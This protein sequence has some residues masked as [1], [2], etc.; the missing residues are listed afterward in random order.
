MNKHVNHVWQY[1]QSTVL[2]AH[3]LNGERLV[4]VLAASDGESPAVAMV[5]PRQLDRHVLRGH[6]ERGRRDVTRPMSCSAL[7]LQLGQKV[8]K[9]HEELSKYNRYI[10]VLFPNMSTLWGTVSTQSPCFALCSFGKSGHQ[11]SCIL[12]AVKAQ[13]PVAHVK[14]ALQNIMTEWTA[15]SVYSL[16]FPLN[17]QHSFTGQGQISRQS[18]SERRAMP[19]QSTNTNTTFS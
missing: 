10:F 16:L 19:T 11:L 1:V 17:F 15:H 4:D 7:A 3:V 14:N 5:L 18:S 12:A 8:S 6:G 2:S 13:R 9:S